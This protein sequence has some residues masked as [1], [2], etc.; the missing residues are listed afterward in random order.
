M[1]VDDELSLGGD[2]GTSPAVGTPLVEGELGV[3]GEQAGL[4]Q[5]G[6][7]SA[8]NHWGGSDLGDCVASAEGQGQMDGVIA[9]RTGDMGEDG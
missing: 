8:G 4:T 9:S 3:G 6:E 7:R 2:D 5:A 1:P